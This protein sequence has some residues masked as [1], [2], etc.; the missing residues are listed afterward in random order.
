MA[1]LS[2]PIRGCR[3]A[4][5]RASLSPKTVNFCRTAETACV[6]ES[7]LLRKVYR[8]G[9]SGSGA[10]LAWIYRFTANGIGDMR[11][12]PPWRVGH[13]WEPTRAPWWC[14]PARAAPPGCRLFLGCRWP[15]CG[16]SPCR[17]T[18]VRFF[19]SRRA[20]SRYTFGRRANESWLGRSAVCSG[21][22]AE[23]RQCDTGNSFV[24]DTR[25]DVIAASRP[26]SGPKTPPGG[27]V[28]GGII[29]REE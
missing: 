27:F 26:R 22:A 11:T 10:Q 12:L 25:G 9:R 21:C 17:G 3:T 2:R 29:R 13:R 14:H 16:K 1:K 7:A 18:V 6:N 5:A 28:V 19:V 15:E 20:E 23:R 4:P 24:T 8:P